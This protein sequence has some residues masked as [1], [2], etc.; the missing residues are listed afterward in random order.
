MT[1][2]GAPTGRR[3]A[4]GRARTG[5]SQVQIE[6][7]I[8]HSP[9]PPRSPLS[10]AGEPEMWPKFYSRPSELIIIISSHHPPGTSHPRQVDPSTRTRSTARQC[11]SFCKTEMDQKITIGGSGIATC[12][13][14]GD[15]RKSPC[16]ISAP[17]GNRR[18]GC[19]HSDQEHKAGR[20][21]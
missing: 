12:L 11:G 21:R 10:S 2:A 20:E 5:T 13:H 4:A 9:P 19:R 17:S 3:R 15:H 1:F 14:M 6:R 7:S 18:R 16:T 8:S